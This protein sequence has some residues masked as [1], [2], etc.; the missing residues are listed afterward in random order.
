MDQLEKNNNSGDHF[1]Y[2]NVVG[3]SK[4]EDEQPLPTLSAR[5]I[6]MLLLVRLWRVRLVEEA[7]KGLC[8]I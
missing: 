3:S 7:G 4:M 8:S 6:K 1:I 5:K 2:H